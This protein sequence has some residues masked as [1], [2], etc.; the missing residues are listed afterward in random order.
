MLSCA[1]WAFSDTKWI[2]KNIVNQHFFFFL[3]GFFFFF[4][5]A[6]LLCPPSGSATVWRH[7]HGINPYP[8]P[9]QKPFPHPNPYHKSKQ[10]LGHAMMQLFLRKML[11]HLSVNEPC[12]KAVR[13][14]LSCTKRVSLVSS[15]YSYRCIKTPSTCTSF[16]KKTCTTWWPTCVCIQTHLPCVSI[17]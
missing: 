5:G 11:H 12:I 3:G 16:K 1:I 7:D 4:W 8:I 10:F 2:L 6:C 15:T 17:W 9:N 13:C 14:H